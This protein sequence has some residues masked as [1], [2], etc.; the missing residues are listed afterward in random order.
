[1]RATRPMRFD[2]MFVLTI[3][4]SGMDD[5]VDIVIG[6]VIGFVVIGVVPEV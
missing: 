3:V 4:V 6:V 2:F 1:M 5:V